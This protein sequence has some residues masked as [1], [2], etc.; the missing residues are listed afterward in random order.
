M[1][2]GTGNGA[3]KTIHVNGKPSTPVT[4]LGEGNAILSIA[5]SK[6]GK[7]LVA[8]LSNGTIKVWNMKDPEA[9]PQD[10]LGR[11]TSGVTALTFSQD[12]GELASSS[13][14]RTMKLSGFP[15]M[16]S[17]HISIENHDLWVYDIIFTPDD[18]ELISCSADKTIRIVSTEN[19]RMA[20]SLKKVLR[21]NMTMEEWKKM[22]GMDIPYRKTR[23][24]LP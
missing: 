15:A 7:S 23:P 9:R 14:D 6:D 3:V 18:K 13:Y 11:H 17:K 16:E 22:V 24:D 10:I 1:A 12:G 19:K 20:E 8:G 5:F 21:R 2:Y 4:L